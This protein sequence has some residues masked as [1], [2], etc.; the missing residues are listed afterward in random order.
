MRHKYITSHGYI[1]IKVPKGHH[2][3]MTSGYAYEHR[4]VAEQK[5]G[6]RLKRGE[7]VHHRNGIRS[8]N[9]I[10]NIEVCASLQIH[11]AKHRKN[12]SLRKPG[13]NNPEIACA[14]GC[15]LTR[16]RYSKD[17]R[18]RQLINGHRLHGPKPETI[19]RRKAQEANRR[20]GK[21]QEAALLFLSESGP[22]L[23]H[24]IADH[25][26]WVVDK[27]YCALARLES[28][29]LIEKRTTYMGVPLKRYVWACCAD[30]QNS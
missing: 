15:G 13:E 23:T 3:A 12:L 19:A 4:L 29:G 9:R 21:V 14:C 28:N 17:G 5:I 18:P 16:P 6:R 24:E 11:K 22:R 27:T 8:D 2:L 7:E 1:M 25:F 26:G 30:A 10:E 20:K